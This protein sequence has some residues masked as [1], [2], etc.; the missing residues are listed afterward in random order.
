[1]KR[2]TVL[3]GL[4]GLGL[5][6]PAG[7]QQQ[8][9]PPAGRRLL[10]SVGISH[11]LQGPDLPSAVPDARLIAESF[12]ALGFEANLLLDP[13]QNELLLA[14]AQLRLL[15]TEADLVV[16]YVAAHG[17]MQNSQ[18]HIITRDT[19]FEGRGMIG[20]AVPESV[21]LQAVNDQPRQKLLFLDTCREIPTAPRGAQACHSVPPEFHAGVHVC[22]AT[23]PGAPAFDGGDGHSP[24]ARALAYAVKQPGLELSELSRVIRLYVLQSTSGMQIPWERSSLLMPVWLQPAV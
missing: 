8:P 1:M 14:L 2:R 23:Q 24:F 7:A 21:L 19:P 17:V 15:A 9:A 10:L 11:Y 18:S 3:A 20:G 13:T 6:P 16:M 4:A 12:A 5:S 22:Y